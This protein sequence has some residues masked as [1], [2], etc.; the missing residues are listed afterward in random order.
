MNAPW[1]GATTSGAGAARP[2]AE[3]ND[4]FVSDGRVGNAWLATFRLIGYGLLT[5]LLLLP[6]IAALMCW[7]RLARSIPRAHHWLTARVI[8]FRVRSEGEITTGKS[9]FFVSNHVSY[10]DIIALGSILQGHFVAK[11]DVATWP[12]FGLLARLC[13]T[14]FIER[15]STGALKQVDI[16]RSRLDRGD[17]LIVFPEG[18]SSDGGRVLPFKST[19]FAA[20]EGKAITVQPISIH[21]SRLNGIPIGRAYRPFYAWYGDMDLA[22]HL[23]SALSLGSAEVVIRFH[24][25]VR[26]ST[27]LDRKTLARYCHAQIS[28]GLGPD[29]TPRGA[30]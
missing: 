16:I 19:L 29:T 20:V 9:V 4:P 23:W 6:Q 10:F 12:I 11:S 8:G 26:A 18:T 27:F 2:L 21:Y 14:L 25:P 15:R 24:A 13:G 17:S 30:A 7:P 22:P 3:K 5:V 28:G 1:D